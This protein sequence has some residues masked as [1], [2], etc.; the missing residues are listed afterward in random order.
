MG[1]AER[2]RVRRDTR[3]AAGQCV[4]CGGAPEP[5]KVHCAA[6]LIR[7]GVYY[8]RNTY[9]LSQ[10]EWEALLL[11]QSGRDP[12][13]GE[14]LT[15]PHVDHCE[16]CGAVRALLNRNTNQHLGTLFHSSVAFQALAFDLGRRP[17]LANNTG[18]S[19]S[20]PERAHAAA[21]YLEAHHQQC[22]A[23]AAGRTTRDHP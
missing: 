12:V 18:M 4:K 5:G 17:H 22:P 8:L 13:T 23:T 11:S 3:R 2:Q 9:G 6:C 1:T 14:E 15:A 7:E 20:T 16:A 19:I 10:G 21:A